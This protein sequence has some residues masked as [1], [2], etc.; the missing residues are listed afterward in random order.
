MISANARRKAKIV[1]GPFRRLPA[2][3]FQVRAQKFMQCLGCARRNRQHQR[4]AN[5]M[6]HCGLLLCFFE[7]NM[8]IRASDSE[9]THARQDR[10]WLILKIDRF[11]GHP[12][13]R[14]I[15]GNLWIEDFAM[16]AERNGAML[17]DQS[18]FY[19]AATPEA[20]SV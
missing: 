13:G 7:N 10:A 14:L 20:D 18:R 4:T 12:D 17:K 16:Q 5:V 1:N 8:R 9:R 15:P 11:R 6:P 19:Q 2:H 3:L